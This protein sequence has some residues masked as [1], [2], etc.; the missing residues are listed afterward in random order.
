[1]FVLLQHNKKYVDTENVKFDDRDRQAVFSQYPV[2]T[3][4]GCYW[5]TVVNCCGVTVEHLNL[6]WSA[7]R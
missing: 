2:M 4:I 3:C 6:G 5:F 1:M 7:S